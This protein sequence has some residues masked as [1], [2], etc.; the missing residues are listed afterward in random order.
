MK[1]IS[2][3]NSLEVPPGYEEMAIEVRERYVRYFRQQPGFVSSTFYRS[4]N[5]DNKVNFV[6]II[7]WDSYESMQ[8]VVNSGFQHAEGINDDEMKVLGQGF[9]PPIKVLPGQFE[10]IGNS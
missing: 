1:P 3:I 6:N 9:P 7:V 4:I 2:V 8:A 10:V 5:P